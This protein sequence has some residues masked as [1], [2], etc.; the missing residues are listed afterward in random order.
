MF[1]SGLYWTSKSY[2]V[3]NKKASLWTFL[4]NHCH[5][6]IPIRRWAPIMMS[7]FAQQW[8]Q[9]GFVN[10]QK[11]QP[12]K[13]SH[14]SKQIGFTFTVHTG[15]N[16]LTPPGTWHV[17]RT[18]GSR[19][20]FLSGQTIICSTFH[21]VFKMLSVTG[22]CFSITSLCFTLFPVCSASQQQKQTQFLFP[23]TCS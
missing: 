7:D 22:L 11:L 15:G 17:T 10:G 4:S 6:L 9:A 5:T 14:W 20:R 16:R 19:S 3:S 23:S 21:L 8:Q 1:L 12:S 13:W 18:E 2:L